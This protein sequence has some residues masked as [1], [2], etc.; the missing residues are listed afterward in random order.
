MS[1]EAL[2]FEIVNGATAQKDPLMADAEAGAN[3]IKVHLARPVSKEGQARLIILKTYKDA[4]S[5]YRDGNT[6]VFNRSL[7]IKR[8]SVVLPA[9]YAR[10][11]G[12]L[13]SPSLRQGGGRTS[14]SMRYTKTR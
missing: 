7:G 11:G 10:V 2:Q 4:K 13:A 6:I 3:Y 5:Y 9:G 8:N 12:K 1:G 14:G